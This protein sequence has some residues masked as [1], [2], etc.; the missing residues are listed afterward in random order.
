VDKATAIHVAG[1]NRLLR[2]LEDQKS[3]IDARLQKPGVD[4]W[5]ADKGGI[6]SMK[7]PSR[8]LG[9]ALGLALLG[10][11][12]PQ[13]SQAQDYPDGTISLVVGFAPGGN[14][15]V[16]ARAFAPFLEK[17]LGVPVIVD[18]RPGAAMQIALEYTWSKPHDGQ[19]L[20][21]HNQQYLSAIEAG[22]PEIPYRTNQWRWLEML[23]NDPA[24]IVVRSDSK[25][26]SLEALIDDMKARPNEITVGLLTGSV[27]LL[28]CKRLFEGLLG[29]S[30][31][32]V[33]QQGGAPMRTSLVGGQLDMICTNASETYALGDDVRALAVFNDEPTKLLPDA[34]PVNDALK[35]MNI[36]ERL[37]NLG[38]VRGIA[39]PEDFVESHPDDFSKLYKAYKAAVNS[40][41]YRDW[42]AKTGRTE[43]TQSL[44]MEKSNDLIAQY[45]DFFEKNK[46]L[47]LG[48]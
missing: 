24:V 26:K 5:R 29:V 47:I 34:I 3:K 42:I 33:P 7:K 14:D 32:E 25:W 37:P 40:D 21:W 12:A 36:S 31:R 13:A 19:T 1:A 23:Q 10:L 43:I 45:N 20:L 17:E 16:S 22:D 11:A 41:G 15:D 28:G 8:L 38:S 39:V 6:E 9:Y 4:L 30:F 18:S 35:E 44:S 48:N 27:Q 46:E 2:D